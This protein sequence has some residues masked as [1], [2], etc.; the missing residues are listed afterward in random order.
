M[1]FTLARVEF[2]ESAAWYEQRRPGLGEEFVQDILEV[3]ELIL[4]DP[5]VWRKIGREVRWCL[6]KRFPFGVIYRIREG[7]IEIVA[8]MHQSRKPGY[9]RSRL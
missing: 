6:A 1:S 7:K 3:I 2:Q 9:W 8:V 5:L 4:Q